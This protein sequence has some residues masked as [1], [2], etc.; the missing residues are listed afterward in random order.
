MD[1]ITCKERQLIKDGKVDE[2]VAM[3]ERSAETG[4]AEACYR[5]GLLYYLGKSV[6]NDCDIA[7]DWFEKAHELGHAK[8][9]YFI[10]RLRNWY[11]QHGVR[12][13]PKMAD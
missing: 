10:G 3:L 2:A 6:A 8:A 9:P 7:W 11:G 13:M 1:S 4:D 5:L 12:V